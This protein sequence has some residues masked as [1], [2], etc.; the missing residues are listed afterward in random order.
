[1]KVDNFKTQHKEIAEIVGK[2]EQ[3]LDPAT[4]AAKS[5]D[6]RAQLIS[7]SGKLSVHLAM[8]D[9]VLYPAMLGSSND[10][11]KKTAET[12]A[13]EMGTIGGVFKAY[14]EKWKNGATIKDGAAAFITETKGVFSA[15]KDRVVREERDLYTLAET[16]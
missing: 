4:V 14:M 11:A 10:K 3:M 13:K 15:L 8:E 2:I 7:L 5:D 6:I 12:F 1:M 9:K 16:V